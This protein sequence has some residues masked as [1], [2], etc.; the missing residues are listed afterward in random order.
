MTLSIEAKRLAK[1]KRVEKLLQWM[2]DHNQEDRRVTVGCKTCHE[3]HN[4]LAATALTA[5]LCF[6][7][8]GK[9]EPWI[10]NPF[11]K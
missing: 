1:V 7:R 11:S 9:C 3:T 8:E 10:R 6:H 5:W 2:L 4:L